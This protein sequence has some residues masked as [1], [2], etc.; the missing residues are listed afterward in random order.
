MSKPKR[1][2]LTVTNDLN[3][4][5]RMSRICESLSNHGFN[6]QLV[7]RKRKNS[8]ALSK[9][10]YGQKR[11]SCLFNR[12][13]LFYAEYNIR[14]FFLL[15]FSSF[16]VVC[17]IDLDTLSACW[18]AG[19]MKGNKV[20]Y[21]AHEYFSESP[22][23]E[24]RDG[25]KRFW[26]QMEAYLI[27]K[28][29]VIYTV[30]SGIKNRF[31][32]LYKREVGLVRNVPLFR[33]VSKD[34]TY[35][36]YAIYQGALNVG[37][38]LEAVVEWASQGDMELWLAGEGDITAELKQLVKEKNAKNVR[39]LGALTLDELKEITTNAQFGFNLLEPM[40]ESYRLSL[41]NK[42]FDYIMAEIPQV[43]IDF[44][45][46][47]VINNEFEVAVLVS[48]LKQDTLKN[49]VNKIGD[50]IAR[51]RLIDNCQRAKKVYNWEQEQPF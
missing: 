16:D 5:Q 18:L 19:R 15:L 8:I 36:N 33:A 30:S 21:D 48:D 32:A 39:F 22:E 47:R 3:Y 14:L 43:C 50:P 46:Y 12:G 45:S 10:K 35:L 1:I 2:I 37:R 42:F 13:F 31:E 11:L 6:V 28:V 4:D 49:A 27:P 20:V 25:V 7:G 23:L 29:D 9:T 41:A 17:G 38:G 34:N 51:A 44:E 24:G 40:G 26:K